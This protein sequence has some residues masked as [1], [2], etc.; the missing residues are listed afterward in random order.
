MPPTTK[1]PRRQP[2]YRGDQTTASSETQTK[3]QRSYRT[4][5]SEPMTV[6][7]QTSGPA[8]C[9]RDI[10]I[11]N[12]RMSDMSRFPC[13][14]EGNTLK[15]SEF[16]TSILPSKRRRTLAPALPTELC[17]SCRSLRLQDVLDLP[18]DTLQ[19]AGLNGHL[20]GTRT[21]LSDSIVTYCSLC[22]LVTTMLDCPVASFETL[23]VRVYSA[24]GNTKKGSFKRLPDT[25]K[26]MDV[27]HLGVVGF[28]SSTCSSAVV[29]KRRALCISSSGEREL[30]FSPQSPPGQI[31][32]ETVTSWLKCCRLLHKSLCNRKKSRGRPLRFIDCATSPPSLVPAPLSSPYLALSYVWGNRG[33]KYSA[34][35]TNRIGAGWSIMSPIILCP[36][37]TIS[38]AIIVTRELG[39]RFLWVD[40]YCIDQ[41]GGK[42]KQSQIQIMDEIYGG[43]E[44]TLVDAAGSHNNNGLPGVSTTRRT[45]PQD[46]EQTISIGNIQI[47]RIKEHPKSSIMSSTWSQRAWTLQEAVLSR[48]LLYFT[49]SEI[50]FECQSMQTR[51]SLYANWALLHCKQGKLYE[52]LN[53]GLFLGRISCPNSYI[54]VP[55]EFLMRCYGLIQ[56]YTQREMTCEED[57]FRAAAGVMRHL[58]NGKVPIRQFSGVPFMLGHGLVGEAQKSFL[59][60]LLWVHR[61]SFPPREGYPLPHPHR[62]HMFPSWSWT[63]WKGEIDFAI[64]PTLNRGVRYTK[65]KPLAIITHFIMEDGTQIDSDWLFGNSGEAAQEVPVAFT[66]RAP[67]LRSCSFSVALMPRKIW[68]RITSKLNPPGLHPSWD[69]SLPPFASRRG[70]RQPTRFY[71]GFK[72]KLHIYKGPAVYTQLSSF[73][74]INGFEMVLMGECPKVTGQKTSGTMYF[75]IVEPKGSTYSRV[76]VLQI[77]ETLENFSEDIFF[78][79]RSITIV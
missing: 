64:S 58:E 51:E 28:N 41:V 25:L 34:N 48:R 18:W 50:Y 61:K 12:T 5:S 72:G 55:V 70:K 13:A 60:S 8:A 63:G 43:A 6:A 62:R 74:E 16:A 9:T 24:F 59:V 30:V 57:S 36:P 53:S 21:K 47:T 32:Y 7:Q 54:K 68:C 45:S 27:P 75:L 42:E 17:E 33:H 46:A 3:P 31:K 56:Q 37:K 44:L 23:E 71:P 22:Q 66:I 4:Q 10:S 38:D 65:F 79:E 19:S 14:Q 11:L 52:Q 29:G 67:I 15:R 76:G 78:E 40:A 35:V 1:V 39:F 2:R 69:P 26:C 77:T 73:F 49:D 20:L